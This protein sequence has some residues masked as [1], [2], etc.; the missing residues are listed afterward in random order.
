MGDY[1]LD[2]SLS[3]QLRPV[4]K[5]TDRDIYGDIYIYYNCKL[6]SILVITGSVLFNIAAAGRWAVG[7]DYTTAVGWM[8]SEKML[9]LPTSGWEYSDGKGGW[10]L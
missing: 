7:P 5:K 8:R 6:Y 1:K 3:A 9:T 10:E 4:Y 2:P